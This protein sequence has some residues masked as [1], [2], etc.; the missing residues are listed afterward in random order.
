MFQFGVT[1]PREKA[2][3]PQAAR[4]FDRCYYRIWMLLLIQINCPRDAAAQPHDETT[5]QS[6]D[7]T[8]AG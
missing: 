6:Q 5:A 2:C 3:A 7:E 8:V 4:G 1:A